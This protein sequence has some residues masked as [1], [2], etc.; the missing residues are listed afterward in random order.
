MR[1][2]EGQYLVE[3]SMTVIIFILVT[4]A[5]IELALAAYNYRLMNTAAFNA[6]RL[7]TTGATDD[8]MKEKILEQSG[9][10]YPTAFLVPGVKEPVVEITPDRAD[11]MRGVNLNVKLNFFQ[12]VS[13][14]GYYVI[15]IDLPIEVSMPMTND[16]F[17]DT[18]GDGQGDLTD[19]DDDGDGVIDTTEMAN[20]TD[21]KNAASL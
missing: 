16:V 21:P 1:R 3:F 8:E 19:N 10:L 11:R 14:M 9:A 13:M 17:I 12:G 7:G 15:V 6:A 20:G 2:R 5:F 18:D 4:V